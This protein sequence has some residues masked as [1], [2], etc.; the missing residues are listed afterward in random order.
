[1]KPVFYV[2][3]D[4]TRTVLKPADKDDLPALHRD[5]LY[6]KSYL[7]SMTYL[8]QRSLLDK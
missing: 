3:T 8:I 1:M 2:W 6:G 7:A 5:L 4:V